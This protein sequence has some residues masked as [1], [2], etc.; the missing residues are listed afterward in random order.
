MPL[1]QCHVVKVKREA[2]RKH[3]LLQPILKLVIL[4]GNQRRMASLPGS[5][6]T[7]L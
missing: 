4:W 7:G 6:G 1:A 2:A 3:N 5:E